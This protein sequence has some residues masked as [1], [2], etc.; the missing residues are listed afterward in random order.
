MKDIQVIV[1]EKDEIIGHKHRHEILPNDIY[2]VSAL[3]IENSAW[4]LL[5]SLR[6]FSKKNNPGKWSAAVAG[7]IDEGESYDENIY[8][9]AQEELGITW[10]TFQK[11]EKLRA[12]WKH[13]YFCQWYFL[14]A[15]L[16]IDEL[17]LEYPQ[18]ELARWFSPDEIRNILEHSPEIFTSNFRTMLEEKYKKRVN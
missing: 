16:K 3:W 10:Y 6:G 1:N 7:T 17:V 5:I 12:K 14:V 13:N 9:E 2:R 15:D 4:E 18:V 8:K 11:W